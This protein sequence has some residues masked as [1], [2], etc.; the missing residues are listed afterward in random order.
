MFHE[1]HVGV[2]L[3]IF[4]LR[5]WCHIK[6]KLFTGGTT[7]TVRGSSNRKLFGPDRTNWLMANQLFGGK[8]RVTRARM[9]KRGMGRSK[10]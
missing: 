3:V 9:G 4:A 10:C 6:I 5:R 2:V 1:E 7:D 8:K